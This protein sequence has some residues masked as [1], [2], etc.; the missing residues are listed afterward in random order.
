MII[1]DL[2]GTLADC[3]HRRKFIVPEKNSDYEL[4]AFNY[5]TGELAHWRHKETKKKFVP[6]WDLFYEFCDL[7]KPIEPT[8]RILNLLLRRNEKVEIWSGRS[9]IVREKT[10][11]WLV[12][13]TVFSSRYPFTVRMRPNKDSTPDE[14]LKEKWLNEQCADLMQAKM[15]DRNP[16]N[17]NIQFVFDDRPK[18]VDM[19]KRREIFVFN[20]YQGCEAF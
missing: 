13:H 11:R 7:D 1:F 10:E 8:I 2:D 15:E 12:Q 17:H 14:Q 6:R 19:W 3:E 20:C 4:A 18:V 9:E 5:N 16:V